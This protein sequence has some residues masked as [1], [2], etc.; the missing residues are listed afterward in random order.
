MAW[1]KDRRL[2][3]VY[4]APRVV[5]ALLDY[6]RG[7]SLVSKAFGPGGLG[8]SHYMSDETSYGSWQFYSTIMELCMMSLSDASEV[9]A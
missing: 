1:W 4:V 5:F 3:I 7:D 6:S 2:T 8:R 9:T